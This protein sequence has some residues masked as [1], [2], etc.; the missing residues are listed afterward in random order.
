MRHVDVKEEN[1][2]ESVPPPLKKRSQG[3]AI[4][5][6]VRTPPLNHDVSGEC[7]SLWGESE[8]SQEEKSFSDLAVLLK[9]LLE[10]HKE[11]IS[12]CAQ[13]QGNN[14]RELYS[15]SFDPKRGLIGLGAGNKIKNH[16][17]K[18]DSEKCSETSSIF[19]GVN[20]TISSS[21]SSAL[22]GCDGVSLDRCDNAVVVGVSDKNLGNFSKTLIAENIRALSK[23]VIGDSRDSLE[24]ESHLVV[25]GKSK[26]FDLHV[27]GKATIPSSS[28]YLETKEGEGDETFYVSPDSLPDIIY[29]NPGHGNI[30]VYLGKGEDNSFEPNKSVIIKDITSQLGVVAPYHIT[31]KVPD[32][33]LIEGA[34]QTKI[35]YREKE[36]SVFGHNEGYCITT[37]S[38][39][40]CFSFCVPPVP[41]CSPSWVIINEVRGNPRQ[42]NANIKPALKE[43]KRRVI[44]KGKHVPTC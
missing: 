35:E 25:E 3:T 27:T 39:S 23:V 1:T 34:K 44:N 22:V 16:R 26:L 42:G 24:E 31:V 9:E 36:E 20:N 38:G 10:H 40:V 19:G 37:S 29:A 14:E 32:V 28:L 15:I 2:L 8:E 5:E 7:S 12:W 21:V 11:S 43:V 30:T 6:G 18:K 17:C 41:E 13:G 4:K 33:S